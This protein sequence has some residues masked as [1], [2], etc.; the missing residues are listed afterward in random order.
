[1]KFKLESLVGYKGLGL[2]NFDRN[3]LDTVSN[4]ILSMRMKFNIRWLRYLI[5][6]SSRFCLILNSCVCSYFPLL[7]IRWS[8]YCLCHLFFLNSPHKCSPKLCYNRSFTLIPFHT[9]GEH[10]NGRSFLIFSGGRGKKKWSE[11]S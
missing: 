11:M 9:P 4:L 5:D 10:Q 6:K 1:M 7:W 2:S 3:A 8:G